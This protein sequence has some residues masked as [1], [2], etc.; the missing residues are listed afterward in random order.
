[1][2]NA[3][4]YLTLFLLLVTTGSLQA[5]RN[6]VRQGNKHLRNHH[7]VAAARSFSKAF[8]LE[9]NIAA[10][11][12][13]A[14]AIAM[15]YH[16]MNKLEEAL[17]WYPDAVGEE[18]NRTDW[19]ISYADAL[20]RSGMLIEARTVLEQALFMN[21]SSEVINKRIGGIKLALNSLQLTKPEAHPDSMLNTGFSDYHAA[22]FDGSVVVS[23]SRKNSGNDRTD[24]RTGEAYS[25]LY[26]SWQNPDATFGELE[27]LAISD[28]RNTGVFAYDRN[29]GR[30]FWTKCKNNKNRCVIMTSSF[31]RNSFEWSKPKQADFVAKKYHYGHP[32]VSNDG[33][34]L[35]FVSDMPGGYGG[36][37]IYRVSMKPDGTFGI[38][39]NL[40]QP[41][42]TEADEL[43]P[44]AAGDSLLFFSSIGH[45]LY[46][47]LDIVYSFN[48]G[49]G[50]GFVEPLLF[51]FN[52]YADDF[53]LV[54]KNGSTEGVFSSARITEEGDNLFVFNAYPVQHLIKGRVV[55][56]ENDSL[57][58]GASVQ[59]NTSE[60]NFS[61]SSGNNG[62]YLVAVPDYLKGS[63][64]AS[65]ESY[66]TENKNFD[67]GKKAQK[68]SV[69]QIDFVLYRLDYPVTISGLVTDR[70]TGRILSGEIIE[71]V[72]SADFTAA[73]RTDSR[74][75]YAF[76]SLKPDQV[77]TVKIAKSGYFT[78]SRLIRIPAVKFAAVF[79]KA[80]GYDMDFQLIR[81]QEKQEIVISNIYY[82][83]D[84]A[85]LRESS[86]VELS[87]L[88][89]LLRENPQVLVQINSHTDVRGSDSYNDRLSE[90]RARS[91]VNYLIATGIAP[92]RLISKGH[93]KR[94]LLIRNARN[95]DEHQ[96]NRRTTFEVVRSDLEV[97]SAMK[98]QQPENQDQSLIFRVQF[99]VS[100]TLRNPPVYFQ[101]LTKSIPDLRF[102]VHDQNGLYRYEAG[103]R[104]SEDSAEALKNQ[105]V[106]GGFVDCFI[107]PYLNGNRISVQ[108]A[109][110]IR[111]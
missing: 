103:D 42:N 105:I 109:K 99:M 9:E 57:I 71:I 12:E 62:E 32:S 39:L 47:G 59:I 73:V 50:F 90:E 34:W 58:A 43:F 93:G 20:Q 3:L 30:A 19:L 67:A 16:R 79:Q 45:S 7:F 96:A 26:Q 25:S 54:M 74:G 13:I 76:D 41:V 100:S 5:Q 31:N 80:T 60:G 97:S 85:S 108:E 55:S 66:F 49:K 110:Q 33:K 2:K 29:R 14:A 4:I 91:V 24:G 27:A 70:E 10:K 98:L 44:F 94:K 92:S 15:S 69:T 38:P 88:S 107:V 78:E 51:P 63:I 48:D 11:R 21:P 87:K 23:S 40:G 65:K 82:D 61:A 83:L 17:L 1:M 81:I 18:T 95:E 84:K 37:D 64:A 68:G 75:I 35:Y 36:K 6:H 53:A 77:Y 52:S 106:A 101:A 89:N 111:P 72:G 102:Y 22:F 8:N 56:A 104:Y 86:K 28:S 46:G